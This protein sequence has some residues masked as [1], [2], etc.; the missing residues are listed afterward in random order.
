V[1]RPS[2]LLQHDLTRRIVE[3]VGAPDHLR[4]ALVRIIHHDSQLVGVEPVSPFQDEVA[5]RGQN[6]VLLGPEQ[7]V[8]KSGLSRLVRAGEW[9]PPVR[10]E[11]KRTTGAG[12]GRALD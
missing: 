2:A 3:Q 11:V 6:I 5:H 1:V 9:Q 7:P 10:G 8:R 12:I 4:D